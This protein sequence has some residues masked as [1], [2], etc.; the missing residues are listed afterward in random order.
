MHVVSGRYACQQVAE[1]YLFL[2]RFAPPPLFFFLSGM[3]Y[4]SGGLLG[5]IWS[6]KSFHKRGLQGTNVI[7]AIIVLPL[8]IGFL[9]LGIVFIVTG[10][11]HL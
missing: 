4:L 6:R 1:R 3:I 9:F 2:C 11:R 8:S 10:F 7:I 5:G